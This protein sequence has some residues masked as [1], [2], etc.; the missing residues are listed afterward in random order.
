MKGCLIWITPDDGRS[1]ACGL[2]DP[3]DIVEAFARLQA[4]G[5]LAARSLV[6]L[7][8][9]DLAVLTPHFGIDAHQHWS[10]LWTRRVPAP[11]DDDG[12]V[13][14]LAGG[15]HADIDALL[16][17]AFPAT[18]NRP[19]RPGI[20]RWFGIRETGEH[21]RHAKRGELVAVGADRSV[22]GVGYLVA[23]AVRQDRQG[24]GYGAAITR[25]LVRELLTGSDL[26]ALGVTDVN[27]RA[28]ELYARMGFAEG[29]DLTSITL[30]LP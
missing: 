25:R 23:V 7:P 17:A 10:V 16:D 19:G 2:G 20:H 4:E 5:G 27:H 6:E 29:I 8:R 30:R 24:R 12:L 18:N 9:V 3:V 22:N 14:P 28:R 26:C 21:G 15:D 11:A 13:T 1:R